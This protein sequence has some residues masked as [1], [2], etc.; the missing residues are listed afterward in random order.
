MNRLEAPVLTPPVSKTKPAAFDLFPNWSAEPF[1]SPDLSTP[2]ETFQPVHYEANYKY[3]LVVWLHGAR[4][5]QRDLPSVMAHVS[6]R[7]YVA[8]APEGPGSLDRPWSDDAAGIAEAEER[9]VEAIEYANDYFN[10]HAERVFVAG[11]GC[12]G[13]AALRMAMA[14]PGF[15]AG[16]ASFDG[17]VPRGNTPLQQIG[18]LRGLPLML[19]T[20]KDSERY[21]EAS[22][23]RDMRLLYMAGCNLHIHQEPGDGETTTSS[24]AEV[25]RWMMNIVCG[26]QTISG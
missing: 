26:S 19:A 4:Q 8:V 24:L 12:G 16:A 11:I 17:P 22:V 14:N 1:E 18:A 23:C 15:I 13:T 25:D 6:T 7:N 2:L 9:I 10:L 3:P 20:G 21:S 5:T